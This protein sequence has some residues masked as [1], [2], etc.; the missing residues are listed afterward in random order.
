MSEEHPFDDKKPALLS[1]PVCDTLPYRSA[2][3]FILQFG[4]ALIEVTDSKGVLVDNIQ[5]DTLVTW[6]QNRSATPNEEALR[7]HVVHW[8]IHKN[9]NSAA[10]QDVLDIVAEKLTTISPH[11]KC[12][13]DPYDFDQIPRFAWAIIGPKAV[14]VKAHQDIFGTASWNL[15][16]SGRKEWQ[17]WDPKLRSVEGNFPSFSFEQNPGD[18]VWIPENWWHS[19]NYMDAS[20][21]FSKNLILKRTVENVLASMKIEAPQYANVLQAILQIEQKGQSHVA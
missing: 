18:L 11:L 12:I 3:D 14:M 13:F 21:C 19:V 15:L 20:I 5:L 9:R 1:F 10:L 17:F 7:G 8:C 2:S 4:D 6:W 16:F